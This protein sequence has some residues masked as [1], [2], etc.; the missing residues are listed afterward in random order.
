M[1]ASKT[2]FMI[3]KPFK[4][5][6]KPLPVQQS[7]MTSPKNPSFKSRFLKRFRGKYELVKSSA[8]GVDKLIRDTKTPIKKNEVPSHAKPRQ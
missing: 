3:H 4:N 2:R 5:Y 7:S 6:V 1:K 8:G